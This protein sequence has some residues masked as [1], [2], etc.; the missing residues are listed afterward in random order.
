MRLEGFSNEH[1]QLLLQIYAGEFTELSRVDQPHYRP[2]QVYTA[3]LQGYGDKC[4]QNLVDP[5]QVRF[6]GDRRV[7]TDVG[8]FVQTDYFDRYLMGVVHVERRLEPAYLMAGQSHLTRMLEY[9]KRNMSGDN[10]LAFYTN[11]S[12][13]GIA[14]AQAGHQLVTLNGCTSQGLA[15]F[16]ARLIE[17]V[18]DRWTP[19]TGDG[20]YRYPDV[21]R[22]S[23]I[24]R[25]YEKV[26]AGFRPPFPVLTDKPIVVL[27]N[28]AEGGIGLSM[29]QVK[30]FTHAPLA[31]KG[32]INRISTMTPAVRAAIAE[33]RYQVGECTYLS[34][35]G[36]RTDFYWN[37]NA[38]LPT[39]E[40]QAYFEGVI[41]AARDSCPAA[42]G[43][44]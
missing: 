25:R 36:S 7:R 21:V 35:T 15:K 31:A 5:V 24:V 16:I 19:A 4:R 34:G 44:G 23:D 40:V 38:P 30:W 37:A 32:Q 41:G 27:L 14:L 39:A 18:S 22:P 17:Y 8:A 3:L 26:P 9:W 12:L 42:A 6:Y 28:E 20:V 1:K 11:E 33:R 10:L 13:K 29:M 43:G 2:F